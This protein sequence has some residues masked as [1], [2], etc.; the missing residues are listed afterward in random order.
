M[1]TIARKDS[2][3]YVINGRKTFITNGP[4]ADVFCV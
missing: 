4:E 1:Q 2:N 3:G